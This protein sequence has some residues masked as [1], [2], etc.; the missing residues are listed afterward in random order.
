[1]L[2]QDLQPLETLQTLW[3]ETRREEQQGRNS[4]GASV[5]FFLRWVVEA[6]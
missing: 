5:T 2:L 3:Q 6:K 1:M 4:D